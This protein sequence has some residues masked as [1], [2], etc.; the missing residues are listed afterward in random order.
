[1]T[2][3][4]INVAIQVLPRSAKIGTYELVDRAIE[5]IQKSGLKYQVCPFETVIEGHYDE[6]MTLLKEVH[7]VVYAF[8][9][10]EMI[11]NV[12]IQTR[13][14]QDVLIEDKMNKYE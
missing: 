7:E 6:I 4:L 2:D 14:N 9:A 13:Y 11:T 12:K 3:K 8:G 1:M 5:V 10:E